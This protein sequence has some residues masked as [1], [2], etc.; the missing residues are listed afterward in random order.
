MRRMTA[1]HRLEGVIEDV[2]CMEAIGETC[3]VV[4]SAVGLKANV[5][6]S[7]V[8]IGDFEV[9]SEAI[10]EP[11][12]AE[13]MATGEEKVAAVDEAVVRPNYFPLMIHFSYTLSIGFHEPRGAPPS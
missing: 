5:V 6:T 1:S 8:P 3:V 7:V 9:E 12:V 2:D 4:D 10:E 11:S 13:G